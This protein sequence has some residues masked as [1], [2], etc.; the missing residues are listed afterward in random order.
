MDSGAT[1]SSP[2]CFRLRDLSFARRALRSSAAAARVE[3]VA[4]IVYMAICA[5][6]VG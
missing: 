1:T 6:E 5:E 2:G 3:C 4:D